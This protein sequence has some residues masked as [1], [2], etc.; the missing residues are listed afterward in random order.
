MNKLQRFFPIFSGKASKYL[1]KTIRRVKSTRCTNAFYA[2]SYKCE[3][4]ETVVQGL[5]KRIAELEERAGE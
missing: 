1:W 2:L 4:L 3:D 5:E